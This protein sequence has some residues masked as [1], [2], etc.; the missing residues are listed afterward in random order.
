[1]KSAQ[2]GAATVAITL[3]LAF[4]ILLSVAFA[5]RSVVFEARTSTNQYRAAQAHEAAEAGIAWALA[6]LNNSTPLGDDCLPSNDP[7][8]LP[9]RERSIEAMRAHCT[10][11]G[12]GWACRCAAAAS[13]NSAALGFSIG[14]ATTDNPDTLQLTSTGSSSSVH[15]Q[16]QIRLGRLPGLDT[17]PAAAL[18]V[19]GAASFSAGGFDIR[20]TS[21]ATGGLTLHSGGPAE[22]TALRL[23]STPG[24]PASVSVL[25]HEAQL[26][27]LTTA[28]LFAS[29]FRMS[30][31]AWRAQPVAQALDCSGPCDTTLLQAAAQH[32]LIWL[33]GG[34]RLETP[35]VLGTPERPV[36]LVADGPIELHA[37]AVIHGLVYATDTRWID[38]A[39]ATIHG[40]V[41]VEGD[42]QAS[43]TTQIRHDAAV[44]DALHQRTGSYARVP[45]SWRDH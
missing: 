7:S 25:S 23:T 21:V 11:S 2:R 8:A 37:A 3:L 15:A 42:L 24:T 5:H 28:G 39:G 33:R 31:E 20:H 34:L 12:N 1:M 18:T 36:L 9:F 30:R 35:A 44:L 19:R 6:Q 40:A 27:Q 38:T 14:V 10:E 29:V 16:L 22:I 13:S 4:V 26:A 45:G 41:I 43:G 17:L 32:Q